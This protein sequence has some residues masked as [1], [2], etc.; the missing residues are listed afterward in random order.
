MSRMLNLENSFLEYLHFDLLAL[1][2]KNLKKNLSLLE[3]PLPPLQKKQ[4]FLTYF[5]PS[6]ISRAELKLPIFQHVTAHLIQDNVTAK[7]LSGDSCD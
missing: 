1:S 3:P 4:S 6:Q 5:K 2:W 7:R